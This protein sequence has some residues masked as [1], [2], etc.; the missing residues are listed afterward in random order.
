[1]RQFQITSPN[2]KGTAILLYDANNRLVKIDVSDTSMSINAI[3]TFKA[4]IPADFDMLQQCIS[5]TKLTVI[6][7]GY[8]IPFDDFWDKYKK[9]VNRLRAIKEWNHLRPEEKI[10]A[11]AG[12]SKYNQYVERTGIGKLDPDNYLKNKRFTDEY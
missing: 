9:K 2:F 6:E 8:V 7:S 11:L 10:K 1:M 3:N 4:Y 5:N 12:I